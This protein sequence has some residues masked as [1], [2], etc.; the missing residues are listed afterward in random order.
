MAGRYGA[1]EWGR[2]STLEQKD[3]GNSIPAQLENC[4]R[5]CAEHKIPVLHRLSVAHSA[6]D[7]YDECPEFLAMIDLAISD[8]RVKWILVDKAN[9]FARA[10]EISVPYKARLRRHGIYLRSA[11]PSEPFIDP[12]TVGGIWVDGTREIMS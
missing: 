3:A 9:R 1:I 12:R 8:T 2:V 11:D 7:D 6:F 10:R 5:F 4:D